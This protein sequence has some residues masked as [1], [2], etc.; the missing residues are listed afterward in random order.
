M[1]NY[2]SSTRYPREREAVD[3]Q[4]TV[5]T[6]AGLKIVPAYDQELVSH[7]IPELIEALR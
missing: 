6:L 3:M 7:P 2:P 5:F 4:G 1:S